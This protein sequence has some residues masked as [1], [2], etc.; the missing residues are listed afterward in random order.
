MIIRIDEEGSLENLEALLSEVVADPRVKA[1]MVLACD[2]NGFTPS[3]SDHLFTEISKPIFGGI[4]PQILTESDNLEKGTIVAGIFQEVSLFLLKNISSHWVDVD[5]MLSIPFEGKPVIGKTT[6]LFVDGMSRNIASL[7]ES[8]FN[9]FGLGSNYIGGGAGSMSFKPIPCII[10]PEGLLKDAAIYAFADMVSGVGVAH[11]WHPV[12]EP[13]KVTET[14]YNT[15]VSLDWKPAFEVYRDIIAHENQVESK[16]INFDTVARSYPIGVV[17]IAD[18]LLVRDPV[19]CEKNS[20]ICLG[21]MPLNS[22]VFI[23]RGD[24][25]SLLAGA[26]KSRQRAESGY[27]SK[28][29][30]AKES[31]PP[32]V[33]FIDCITRVLYLEDKFKEE[34]TIAAGGN[35]LIGALSLGEIA[36]SGNDYLEF[37]NKT[38]VV[39]IVES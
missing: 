30:K 20:M 14:S 12:S 15:V 8:T 34:L 9:H 19:K 6:F 26:S 39:G 4:F 2:A 38:S 37:Y 31:E 1:V 7:L 13:L 35:K 36:N 10:T 24:A 33:F 28:M 18:E 23:L 16:D 32:V 27:Y 25:E 11:G 3:N 22:F 5:K 21:E 29:D 17:K